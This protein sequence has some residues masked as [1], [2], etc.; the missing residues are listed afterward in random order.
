ME[1][2]Q[3]K[4]L[5]VIALLPISLCVVAC[6]AV[7][8]LTHGLVVMK[9]PAVAGAQMPPEFRFLRLDRKFRAVH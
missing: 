6:V 7:E 8:F 9:L 4:A 2:I 1:S 5:P 3:T